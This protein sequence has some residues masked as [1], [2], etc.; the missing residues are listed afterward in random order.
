MECGGGELVSGI[1]SSNP[2]IPAITVQ[3]SRL[4]S[5]LPKKNPMAQGKDLPRDS[6]GSLAEAVAMLVEWRVVRGE[7]P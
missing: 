4:S 7:W 3:S 1:Q 5:M 2:E 6:A